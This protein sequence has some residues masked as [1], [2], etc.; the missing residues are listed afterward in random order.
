MKTRFLFSGALLAPI[1]LCAQ[2]I[3]GEVPAGRTALDLSIDLQL[4]TA[5]TVDSADM[6]I[7]CD[8]S[9]DL[10]AVLYRSDPLVDGTNLAVLRMIDDDLEFCMDPDR[11]SYHADG[12][13]MDCTGS[14]D[15]VTAGDQILGDYGGFFMI[16]PSQVDSLYIAYKQG[17]VPGWILVSFDL[18]VLTGCRLQVHRVLSSCL[19]TD[20]NEPVDISAPL[21]RPNPTQGEEVQVQAPA[22]WQVMELAD[23]T[24]R[25]IA[26]YGPATRSIPAPATPGVHLVRCRYA[27]GSYTNSR[28]LRL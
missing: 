27:D 9:P 15:W 10:R 26:R 14:Y 21:L 18:E 3:A 8:D 25:V 7:D 28:L 11:P 23:A 2:L 17:G 4:N 22:G 16:G 5:N 12:E 19:S 6:E 24:G 1:P 20:I 13:P